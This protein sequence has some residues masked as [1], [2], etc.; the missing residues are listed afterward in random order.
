MSYGLG[1][2]DGCGAAILPGGRV[3]HL[4]DDCAAMTP[5]TATPGCARCGAAL[6]YAGALYCG[7]A[8]SEA[9]ELKIPLAVRPA[10]FP[11]I[12]L[13]GHKGSGKDTVA[14]IL[15]SEMGWTRMAFADLLKQAA[16][17]VFGLTDTQM[18][19]E[20]KEVVDHYW[21]MTPRTILQRMGTEAMR[22][23]FGPNVWV[24]ALRRQL[25]TDGKIVITDVRFESEMDM[26]RTM[27]GRCWLVVR[28]GHDGD[29]HPS[30]A[31]AR[32]GKVWDRRIEND[33]SKW[34][35]YERVV[36]LFNEE[37]GTKTS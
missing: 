34:K 18:N 31:L 9:A 19:G 27:C 23:T 26:V 5:K 24:N 37:F 13:G 10:R 20:E 32:N 1:N 30:E 2:C 29:D 7:A 4:S 25:P 14:G 15:V 11:L 33:A 12:G 22:G 8:C 35:L 6:A 17:V 36:R 21:G 16:A 28:P 3:N